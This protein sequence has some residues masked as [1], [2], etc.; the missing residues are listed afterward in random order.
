MTSPIRCR[1]IIDGKTYN[2]ETSINVCGP[3]EDEVGFEETLF[4]T[5]FGAYFIFWAH[6]DGEQQGIKPLDDASAEKWLAETHLLDVYEAEFGL[7]PE[8]GDDSEARITLRIPESLRRKIQKLAQSRKQS[9]NTV[10]QQALESVVR[11]DRQ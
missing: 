1:R 2:T 7:P 11:E 9:I 3:L 5:R 10:I 8:A 4:K 6:P